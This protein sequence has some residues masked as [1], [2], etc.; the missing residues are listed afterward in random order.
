MHLPVRQAGC[1]SHSPHFYY[2]AKASQMLVRPPPAVLLTDDNIYEAR[3]AWLADREEAELKYGHVS[4]WDVS[5][6]TDLSYIWCGEHHKGE[7]NPAAKAFD[8]DIS[9]WM[10]AR[11]K[12]MKCA[13]QL[14]DPVAAPQHSGCEHCALPAHASL[15]R[16]AP[17]TCSMALLPS[18]TW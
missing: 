14:V 18:T 16:C 5:R 4:N 1:A 13:P 12:S 3:D 2:E 7:C 9:R 15:C 6:V 11:A 10:T 17:Q 8:D